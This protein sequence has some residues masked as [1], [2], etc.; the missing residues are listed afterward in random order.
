MPI[1]YLDSPVLDVLQKD[2]LPRQ[3]TPVERLEMLAD[4]Q[5]VAHPALVAVGEHRGV[6]RA[7]QVGHNRIQP[8]LRN[9]LRH[10]NEH[11]R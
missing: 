6:I 2:N 4:R 11:P 8:G 3:V 10:A 7:I 9:V 5:V 1:R